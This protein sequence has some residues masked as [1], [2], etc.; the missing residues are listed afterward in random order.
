MAVLELYGKCKEL[1][2]CDC[3]GFFGCFDP[4]PPLPKPLIENELANAMQADRE[5]STYVNSNYRQELEVI[6]KSETKLVECDVCDKSHLHD[7]PHIANIEGYVP[8]DD[9]Y[10]LSEVRNQREATRDVDRVLPDWLQEKPESE[11]SKGYATKRRAP[12]CEQ[13]GIV[14]RSNHKCK[15]APKPAD[16]DCRACRTIGRF[17]A[18][19]GGRWDDYDTPKLA[20][21]RVAT[22]LPEPVSVGLPALDAPTPEVDPELA[23]IGE[24]LKAVDGLNKKQLKRVMSYVDDR[25]WENE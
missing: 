6:E 8:I 12:L 7:H 5:T 23:A 21:V 11:P 22:A 20:D 9:T 18:V 15:G 13:C 4:Q 1:G 3:D 10:A 17:C 14:K 19:H 16:A 24:I 25:I 2:Y